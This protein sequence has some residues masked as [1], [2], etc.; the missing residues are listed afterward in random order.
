MGMFDVDGL[1][2]AEDR[3]GMYADAFA[4]AAFGAAVL[5]VFGVGVGEWYLRGLAHDRAVA[6]MLETG[7]F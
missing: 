6:R 7:A 3:A 5:L 4:V 1:E 2:D